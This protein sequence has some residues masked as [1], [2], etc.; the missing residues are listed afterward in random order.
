MLTQVETTALK[1]RVA[2]GDVWL[3]VG[4]GACLHVDGIG[5]T[6]DDAPGSGGTL[7]SDS[8]LLAGGGVMSLAALS[9]ASFVV[10]RP[11]MAP[12]GRP[13]NLAI[14][15]KAERGGLVVNYQRGEVRLPKHLMPTR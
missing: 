4:N 10:L 13:D 15:Q 9:L 11:C 6:G 1:E 5:N 2:S 7:A 12:A 3:N 8:A 14:L